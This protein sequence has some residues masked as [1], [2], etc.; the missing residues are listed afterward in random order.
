MQGYPFGPRVR[1][2][3]VLAL[4]AGWLAGLAMQIMTRAWSGYMDIL[5]PQ[6]ILGVLLC[7]GAGSAA[8]ALDRVR[9]SAWRGAIAGVAMLGSIIAGYA[10]MVAIAWNP[11]WNEGDGGETWFSLLIELPFWVGVPLVAGSTCGALGWIVVDRL[12]RDS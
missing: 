12:A 4:A 6:M 8:R 11:I 3:L 9:G 10:L 1:T 5:P 7:F 2:A